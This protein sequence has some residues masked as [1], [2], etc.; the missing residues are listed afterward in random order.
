MKWCKYVAS[1][2]LANSS[3]RTRAFIPSY[4]YLR[5]L[6]YWLKCFWLPIS[7]WQHAP[8]TL[9]FFQLAQI[10]CKWM[11]VT[12]KQTEYKQDM[13]KWAKER[14]TTTTTAPCFASTV[15][16]DCVKLV[17]CR[18]DV[19]W[20]ENELLFYLPRMPC[21]VVR[22]LLLELFQSTWQWHMQSKKQQHS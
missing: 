13:Q 4:M 9:L 20:K 5:K 17:D 15:Q 7:R 1:K 6:Y 8:F 14:M 12:V 22:L 21:A 2:N 10:D 11:L 19:A 3:I 18:S 16:F